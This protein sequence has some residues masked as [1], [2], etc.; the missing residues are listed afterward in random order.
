MEYF[1]V[2]DCT[3]RKT[4]EIISRDEAHRI[5]AWHGAFHC[6]IIS[7]QDGGGQALFQKRSA[8][9]KIAPGNLM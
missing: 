3:G 7:L 6:L 1:D 8:Q 5:G 9:K 4:G 2:L